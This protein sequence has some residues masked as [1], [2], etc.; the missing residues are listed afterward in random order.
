MTRD[1][2]VIIADTADR[3]AAER[4]ARARP[5]D[6]GVVVVL[7]AAGAARRSRLEAN[8]IVTWT[9]PASVRSAA[10]GGS[11][12]GRQTRRRRAGRERR[13]GRAEPWG[14]RVDQGRRVLDRRSGGRSE[15][16]LAPLF[17]AKDAVSA[18]V[19]RTEPGWSTEH[20]LVL[21]PVIDAERPARIIVV[22][23]TLL[24]VAQSA[25]R[26]AQQQGR[27]VA[28][29]Q[30]SD[31]HVTATQAHTRSR[32]TGPGEPRGEPH[33]RPA[34]LGI[35]PTNSAGQG[36]A[37]ARAAREHLGV[38][39]EVIAIDSGS[40]RYPCDIRVS[41]RTFDTDPSW[42]LATAEHAVRTWTHALVESGRSPFGVAQGAS[43]ADVVEM[44]AS[45][46]VRPALVFHGSDVRDPDRHAREFADSPF[47]RLDRRYVAALRATAARNRRLAHTVECPV[48][49][50]TP[51]QLDDLP[52]A[53]WLPVVIDLGEWPLTEA[54][55]PPDV[56]LVVHAPSNP[57]LKGTDVIEA[58]VAPLVAAGSIRYQAVTGVT[59]AEAADWVRR[60]DIVID[61]LTLGLYGVLA[62]E[63]LASGA[64]VI[65]QVGPRIRER[66]PA[67]VPIV[68]AS[69]ATLDGVLRDAVARI[70]ELRSRAAERR[71]FVQRF[72][73]GLYSAEALGGLLSDV[74][75]GDHGSPP[76]HRA[77]QGTDERGTS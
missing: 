49:V 34:V 71:G 7:L 52:Q 20:E 13:A 4:E 63:A 51:D 65:G 47:P 14:R 11:D 64:V 72:H 41:R 17:R 30:P 43:A 57:R 25:V 60:A 3:A 69:P 24:G 38:G 22:T 10:E 5:E 29:Q 59:P 61:Q 55:D 8:G 2:C 50:S 73:D 36:S 15:V 31:G 35:G 48:F 62:C 6:E 56:P 39:T 1:V 68:E 33:R 28:I 66:V 40:Y 23:A 42:G 74:A 77:P 58:V 19:S 18:R 46:G 9:V 54:V 27:A 67:P 44:L 26:R 16:A 70:E 53:T 76:A 37:W 45:A 32:A 12:A 21:G 75:A